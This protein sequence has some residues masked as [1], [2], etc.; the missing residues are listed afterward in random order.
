[1]APRSSLVGIALR[2]R[3]DVSRLRF[4]APVS[5]VHNPLTYAWAFHREYLERFGRGQHDV[6]IVGM[7][8]GYFGMVQTGVRFGDVPLVRD[9]IGA[10]YAIG[11]GA[12]VPRHG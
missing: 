10:R 1:M 9:A 11:L 6:L 12:T 3:E 8:A 7:D 4:R 5:H 2:L